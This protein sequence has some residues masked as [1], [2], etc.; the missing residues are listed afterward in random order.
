MDNFS[1]KRWNSHLSNCN[2]ASLQEQ[3]TE[4][5]VQRLKQRF[6]S[7]YDITADGKLQIQEVVDKLGSCFTMFQ[8][9]RSDGEETVHLLKGV[10]EQT[11]SPLSVRFCRHNLCPPPPTLHPPPLCSSSPHFS[12][13]TSTQS[14]FNLK[15]R[16]QNCRNSVSSFFF[17]FFCVFLHLR[18]EPDA[19]LG[20]VFMLDWPVP[21]IL[22]RLEYFL[23][24]CLSLWGV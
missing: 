8:A 13:I 20:T 11:S 6:M 15:T 23:P 12:S 5:R 21:I 17:S 7:A 24:G 2:C 4:E 10:S 22:F 1:W 16:L 18:A 19:A 9:H 3:A 14:R